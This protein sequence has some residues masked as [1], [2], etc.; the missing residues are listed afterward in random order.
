MRLLGSA[1]DGSLGG[2]QD[3]CA[4]DADVGVDYVRDTF[5]GPVSG[6]DSDCKTAKCV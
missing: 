2:K 3:D 5:E 1:S 6:K 4:A